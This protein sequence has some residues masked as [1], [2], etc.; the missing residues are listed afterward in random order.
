[1]TTARRIRAAAAGALLAALAAV[2]FAAGAQHQDS[3]VMADPNWGVVAP[4][5]VAETDTTAAPVTN[6][7]A[8]RDP[9]WD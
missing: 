4:T 8:P 6:P 2:A 9:N 1:M 7:P 3:N 5:P